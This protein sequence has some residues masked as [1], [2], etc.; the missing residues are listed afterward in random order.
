MEG[1]ESS[2]LS[3][4]PVLSCV[5][6]KDTLLSQCLTPPRCMNGNQPFHCHGLTSDPGGVEILLV[7]SIIMGTTVGPRYNKVSQYR[8]NVRYSEDPIVMNY[9]V[10]DKNIRYSRVTKLTN[11]GYTPLR[12]VYRLGVNSYI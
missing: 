7:A 1:S 4:S 12:T 2:G 11:A 3:L 6:E 5:L 10:N 8:K 9:L